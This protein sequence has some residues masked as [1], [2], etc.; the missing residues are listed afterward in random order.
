MTVFRNILDKFFETATV[1]SAFAMMTVV[2]IQIICR[3]PF[4]TP[5][6]WTEEAARVFFVYMIAFGAGLALR[7]GSFVSV[8]FLKHFLPCKIAK[9]F[10]AIIYFSITVLMIVILFGSAVYIRIGSKQT[11]PS[12]PLKM[13]F[14]F[15]AMFILSFSMA[16]YALSHAWNKLFGPG[17]TGGCK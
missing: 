12:L 15:A 1:I 6:A 11:S 2:I 16:Y 5:P 13:S 10:D 3:L 17:K 7:E 9:I 4:F 8:D 14:V